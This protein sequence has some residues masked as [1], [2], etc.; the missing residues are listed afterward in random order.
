[1]K[2]LRVTDVPV[3]TLVAVPV[4]RAAE[5]AHEGHGATTI[6]AAPPGVLT[7][8][9]ASGKARESGYD[10][11]DM[12]E[13]TTVENAADVQCAHAARGL[14]M[15]DRVAAAQCSGAAPAAQAPPPV[16]PAPQSQ[17]AQHQH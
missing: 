3:F 10:G 17:P 12:M 15:L 16:Q 11:N 4:A 14:V 5:H 9:P 7:T 6:P 1:M 8:P 13:S 2:L